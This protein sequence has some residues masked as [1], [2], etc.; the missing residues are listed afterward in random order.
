MFC[1]DTYSIELFQSLSFYIFSPVAPPLLYYSH[2]PA[3]VIALL[4]SLF[5]IF[6]NREA[7]EAKILVTISLLYSAWAVMNLFIW[8]YIDTRLIMYLWSFWFS[9]FALIFVLSFYF[10][11]VFI[12]KKDVKFG[13]K[14]L[15]TILLL[16]IILL[17]ST[18]YNLSSFDIS[19]CNANENP[20]MIGYS[21][22][23]TTII[24]ISMVIFSFNEY[25][26]AAKENKKQI[27]LVSLGVLLFLISFSV[28]TYIPSILSIFESE[29]D[30]FVA[31]MYGFFG[32]TIFIGFPSYLIV[33]YKAFN[34]KDLAAQ[35]LVL[36]LLL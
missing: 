35:A 3:A 14:L 13:V 2:V 28:A 25:Y 30:T 10:L 20:L 21:Y 1:T 29:I 11:Y 8:T 34:I 31:E 7:L 24:F 12:K 5:I 15:F 16:P 33:R 19:G 6:K 36:A 23:L 27:V 22:I 26:K 9:L 17:A 4:L 32:M 18:F